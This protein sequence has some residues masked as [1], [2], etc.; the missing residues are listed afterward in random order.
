[1]I[2]RILGEG[3][4]RLDGAAHGAVNAE[5]DRVMAA[6]ESGDEVAFEAALAA[7]VATIRRHG[8][9]VPA[10]ELIGSD[11]IVPAP[12]TTLHEARSLLAGDG[13]IPG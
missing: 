1:M 12:D 7:L 2:V 4:F 10:D 6:V 3:Q 11:A 5:D 9:P 8:V 13:L